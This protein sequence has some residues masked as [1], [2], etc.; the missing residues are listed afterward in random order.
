[1]SDNTTVYCLK[2][3]AEESKSMNRLKKDIIDTFELPNTNKT[4][5]FIGQLYQKLSKKEV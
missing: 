3:M 5:D 1:M 2:A 4:N